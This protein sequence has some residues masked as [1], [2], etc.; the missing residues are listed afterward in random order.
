MSDTIQVWKDRYEIERPLGRGGMSAV[1]LAK[2]RQLLSKYVVVKVLLE[3]I[4]NDAWMQ[5]KFKQE[6]EALARETQQD[7]PN[8]I[9]VQSAE[10]IAKYPDFNAAEALS[11]IPGI[12]LS[13]DTGE[14]RFVNIRGID[15]NLNGATYGGVVLLNTNP[16]GTVFGSGRAV[17]FDTIP[18]GAIDGLVVTKTGMP[19]HDAEGLGGTVELEPRADFSRCPRGHTA[20]GALAPREVVGGEGLRV[21]LDGQDQALAHRVAGERREP[22]G[23]PRSSRRARDAP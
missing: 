1:Y 23:R 21:G 2:D 11:R 6:M 16:A 20:V 15:G 14:G 8:L 22:L 18:T 3:E 4:N 9:N 5:Q 13:S 12:S 10:A 7:A 17:E 19:N